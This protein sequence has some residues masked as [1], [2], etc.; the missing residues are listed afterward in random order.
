[1]EAQTYKRG[2]Y[3][4]RIC[5]WCKTTD[6]EMFHFKDRTTCRFCSNDIITIINNC[7]KKTFDKKSASFIRMNSFGYKNELIDNYDFISN[8][9]NIELLNMIRDCEDSF[10]FLQTNYNNQLKLYD[11]NF[12]S[13]NQQ[14]SESKQQLSESKQ[15]LSDI[16]QQ[17]S[18]INH[19]LSD[20]NQEL[21]D[22]NQK[23]Y[24][25][26]KKYKKHKNFENYET[27]EKYEE[28]IIKVPLRRGR[29][30]KPKPEPEPEE[31][32]EDEE[33]FE[34]EEFEKPEEIPVK[35]GRGRPKK[36][37]M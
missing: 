31:V 3:K 32:F 10:T 19:Q 23:L 5:K 37:I 7:K 34:E 13:I 33:V 26:K 29:K 25:L 4:E 11:Q 27:P 28:P 1:M 18:N 9:S 2:N 36:I 15:Q 35:R 6:E 17:L 12:I 20:T 24:D 30:P 14:L 8:I 21:Y 22:T 16:N